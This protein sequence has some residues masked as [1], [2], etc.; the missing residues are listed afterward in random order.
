MIK[1]PADLNI[2]VSLVGED[3]SDIKAILDSFRTH[4]RSMGD[5]MVR[6]LEEESSEAVANAAHQLKSIALSIGANHL[7]K[8]CGD[9]EE[10][11]L[12]HR[13]A[14]TKVL[15]PRAQAELTAVLTYLDS[16]D[17]NAPHAPSAS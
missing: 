9:M 8:L 13:G 6:A 2:L 15:M 1:P 12:G 17:F 11:A 3:P 4:S 16:P 14:L 5:Q 10:A 7:G